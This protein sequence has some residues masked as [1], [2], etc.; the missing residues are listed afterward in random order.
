M[1]NS[2]RSSARR[3]SSPGPRPIGSAVSA[4]SGAAVVEAARHLYLDHPHPGVH[5]AA[6]LLL[7]RWEGAESLAECDEHLRRR[8]VG[9]DGLGWERGPNGH[10]FAILPAPLDFR[11]GSPEH[12]HGHSDEQTLHHRKIDRSLAVSMTEVTVEQF[13][14]FDKDHPQEPATATNRAAPP[15]TCRLVPG[16]AVLQLAQ[17]ARPGSTR[18]SGATPSGPGP[19]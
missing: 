18:P 19:A 2:T 17:R 7:R 6:G 15:G 11:M 8:R 16:R 10:T 5:A 9:P 4:A 13:R 12:E 14:K 1:S 3:C